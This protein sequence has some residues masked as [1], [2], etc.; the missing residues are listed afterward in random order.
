[1]S[2]SAAARSSPRVWPKSPYSPA[3]S[4]SAQHRA[5]WTCAGSISR[6]GS[7]LSSFFTR[8]LTRM[9]GY[10]SRC[11][12]GAAASSMPPASRSHCVRRL[13]QHRHIDYGK[14]RVRRWVRRQWRR[15][16]CTDAQQKFKGP[17]RRLKTRLLAVATVEPTNASPA[18]VHHGYHPAPQPPSNC[19]YIDPANSFCLQCTSKPR[20]L[21]SHSFLNNFSPSSVTAANRT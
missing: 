14:R 2:L 16:E 18:A 13:C 4:Q 17:L 1:M 3:W 12:H 11:T 8:Y 9:S 6:Y 5:H 7:A 19:S 21:I 10:E 20:A 15:H